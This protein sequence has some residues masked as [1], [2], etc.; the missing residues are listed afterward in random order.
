[1]GKKIVYRA[2]YIPGLGAVD[3]AT[4]E[5]LGG[6]PGCFVGDGERRRRRESF[7]RRQAAGERERRRLAERVSSLEERL[8]I[9]GGNE[10]DGEVDGEVE[11]EGAGGFFWAFFGPGGDP[12]P[13]LGLADVGRLLFLATHLRF[14]GGRLFDGN[15]CVGFGGLGRVLRLGRDA[16][17][18]WSARMAGRGL[19]S[20]GRDGSARLGDGF[21]RRGRLRGGDG[22]NAARAFDKAVRGLYLSPGGARSLGLLFRLLPLADPVSNRLCVGLGALAGTLGLSERHCRRL[23]AGVPGWAARIEWGS[24]KEVRAAISPRLFYCGPAAGLAGAV[25][26]FEKG[27]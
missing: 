14:G 4:G 27:R 26:E 10:V 8:G 7:R 11:G 1:M 16:C 24:G 12:F 21:F 17:S 6:E 9:A 20:A 23:L 5:L 2:R 3:D 15:D 18:R 25:R 22:P 13:G 19:V